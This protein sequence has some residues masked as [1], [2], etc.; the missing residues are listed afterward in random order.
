MT[1]AEKTHSY[2]RE[3]AQPRVVVI[4]GGLGGLCA[5][6]GLVGAPVSVTLIESATT[7]SFVPCS[8]R[9]RPACYQLTKFPGRFDRS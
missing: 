2:K 3:T 7:I 1:E 8:T 4:G 9:W 6:H 5:A